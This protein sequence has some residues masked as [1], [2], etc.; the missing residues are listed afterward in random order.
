M[1]RAT[2]VHREHEG[3]HQIAETFAAGPGRGVV[4][5]VRCPEQTRSLSTM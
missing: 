3:P 4:I 1:K 5:V 2:H